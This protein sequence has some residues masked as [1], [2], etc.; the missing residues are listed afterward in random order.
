MARGTPTSETQRQGFRRIPAQ[1]PGINV[2]IL[3]R[4]MACTSQFDIYMTSP[5]AMQW[6]VQ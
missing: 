5:Q 1:S 6:Y 4:L 3:G 2:D